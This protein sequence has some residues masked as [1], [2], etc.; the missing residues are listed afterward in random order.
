MKNEVPA[1]HGTFECEHFIVEEH[2]KVSS[3]RAGD[4]LGYLRHTWEPPCTFLLIRLWCCG[5]GCGGGCC[6]LSG[7]LWF[8][9]VMV[10]TLCCL[11]LRNGSYVPDN[12]DKFAFG[13]SET[14]PL[15]AI[16]S[17]VQG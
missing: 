6:Y 7:L 10:T 13:E 14:L 17:R 2:L 16:A 12:R 11:Q 4:A 1:T 5:G 9:D 3:P 15:A 8:P